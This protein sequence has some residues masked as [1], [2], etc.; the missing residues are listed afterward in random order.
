[1]LRNRNIITQFG[2]MRGGTQHWP[3]NGDP[4]REQGIQAFYDSAS[5][6][7]ATLQTWKEIATELNCGVRTVQRWERTLG[8]PVRRLGKGSR[9]RVIAF[10]DELHC[11]LRDRAKGPATPKV[12]LQSITDLL[13]R[14]PSSVKQICDRCHSP[15]KFLDGHFWIYGTSRKWNLSV[16]F[17]PLCEAEA[18]ESFCRSQII[19]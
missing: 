18:L 11:W 16:P 14:R 6:T 4:A 9:G 5:A 7:R 3:Q 8:L 2:S 19:H 17:C 12:G 10:K 13:A 1:M 15:M